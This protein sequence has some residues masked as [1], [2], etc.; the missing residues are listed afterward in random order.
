MREGLVGGSIVGLKL[1][2][3]VGHSF[4][5]SIQPHTLSRKSR[6]SGPMEERVGSSTSGFNPLGL[7][8]EDPDIELFFVLRMYGV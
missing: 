2:E 7:V 8:T 1:G 3:G 5:S 4:C 6:S